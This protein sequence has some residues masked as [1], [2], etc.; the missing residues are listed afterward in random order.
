M[1]AGDPTTLDDGTMRPAI[2]ISLV[3][4]AALVVG[5]IARAAPAKPEVWPLAGGWLDTVKLHFSRTPDS[6]TE[7]PMPFTPTKVTIRA[8]DNELSLLV[9]GSLEAP[10]SWRPKGPPVVY[11]YPDADVTVG[12]VVA[13]LD[14]VNELVPPD[15]IVITELL[16]P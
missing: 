9:Y 2:S 11:V 5:W 16:H 14:R 12:D 8:E 4:N 6:V 10:E 1:V 15:T 7:M 3:I 13:A